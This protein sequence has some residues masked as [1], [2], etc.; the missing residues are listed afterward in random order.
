MYEMEGPRLVPRCP[1]K[2]IARPPDAAL[3]SPRRF[4]RPIARPPRIA[5]RLPRRISKPIAQ[6]LSAAWRHRSSGSRRPRRLPGPSIV[7][8]V[9]LGADP[10]FSGERFLLPIGS[11]AQALSARTSRFFSRPQDICCLSPVHGGFP[12][13]STQLRPQLLGITG[14]L[15]ADCRARIARAPRRHHPQLPV[16][17]ASPSRGSGPPPSR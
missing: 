17:C 4:G 7:P 15:A 6:K 12:P 13:R 16:R 11:A 1:G 8:L 10:V 5:W 2:P 9:S 3:H 14:P